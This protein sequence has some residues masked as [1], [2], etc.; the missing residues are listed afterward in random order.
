VYN[1]WRLFS[2]LARGALNANALCT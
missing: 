2:R 1:K